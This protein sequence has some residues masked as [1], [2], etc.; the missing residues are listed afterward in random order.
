MNEEINTITVTVTPDSA[1]EIKQHHRA[2]MD[3][4]GQSV[5]HVSQAGLLLVK[6]REDR[7]GS[8]AS[9][10][11]EALPFTRKTA[12]TYMK[13]GVAVEAGELDLENLTS[14]RQALKLLPGESTPTTRT[15][16][17]RFDSI[18]NLCLKIE[19]AFN[20]AVSSRPVESWSQDERD[21]L[22]R[23]LNSVIGLRDQI[24]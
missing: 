7:R 5:S 2:A 22:T 4:M 11:E 3:S 12:Y 20:E 6:E 16:D 21:T 8:F 18:P 13:I 10:V 23:S 15:R 24:S 14:I 9:W 1:D 17:K 19:Q